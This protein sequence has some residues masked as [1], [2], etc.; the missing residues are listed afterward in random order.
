MKKSK[1]FTLILLLISIGLFFTH[2]GLIAKINF[3]QNDEW[4]YYATLE[5]YLSGRYVNDP[6][7]PSIFYGVLIWAIP[8]YLMGSTIGVSFLTF[9]ISLVNFCV[10]ALTVYKYYLRDQ[11]LAVVIGLMLF[12]NPIIF[13]FKSNN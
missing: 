2:F 12:F 13:N 11:F 8:A 3:I 1:N 5:N 10:M 7:N 6:W 4:T 9:I